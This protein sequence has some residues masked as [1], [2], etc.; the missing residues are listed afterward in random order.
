MVAYDESL[1]WQD[2]ASMQRTLGQTQ[3]TGLIEVGSAAGATGAFTIG[4][5]LWSLRSGW[6]VTTML[7]QMPAWGFVNP[8]IV[9]DT[10]DDKDFDDKDG[11]ENDSLESILDHQDSIEQRQTSGWES[12]ATQEFKNTSS[13]KFDTN[14]ASLQES[15]LSFAQDASVEGPQT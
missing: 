10:L 7:A 8:L 14:F 2:L 13:I 3:S 1:L 5:V 15:S 9:L 11:D 4:Y 12:L 6:L